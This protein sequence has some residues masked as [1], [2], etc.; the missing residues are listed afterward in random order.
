MGT[1]M[2]MAA[3]GVALFVA[4]TAPTA[5]PAVSGKR[6]GI[7]KARDGGVQIDPD[8]AVLMARAPQGSCA[9]DPTQDK[10][11]PIRAVVRSDTVD[12]PDGSVA[13]GPGVTATTAA[14]SSASTAPVARAAQVPQCFLR[15]NY[16]Y[17]SAGWAWGEGVNTCTAAA[18]EQLL[19]VWLK[20]TNADSVW[21]QLDVRSAEK[22]GGGTIRRTAGYNCGHSNQRH[23][24]TQSDGYSVVGGTMYAATAQR[25]EWLTCPNT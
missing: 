15:A 5:V 6:A 2:V 24:M 25:R 14:A 9:N 19:Y 23:Y 16:P 11:P 8:A 18:E 20:R 12:M 7:A 17:Y 1:R 22:L 4:V 3:C 10:C 21:V 13:Y